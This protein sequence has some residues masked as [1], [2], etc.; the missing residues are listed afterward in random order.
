M[1]VTWFVLYMC[2]RYKMVKKCFTDQNMLNT[3]NTKSSHSIFSF[4]QPFF[5]FGF[6]LILFFFFFLLLV[7]QSSET[8]KSKLTHQTVTE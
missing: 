6:F 7:N 4:S 3:V 2:N 5:C 8:V 1:H